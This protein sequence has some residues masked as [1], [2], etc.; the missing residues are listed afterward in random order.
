MR[1]ATFLESSRTLAPPNSVLAPSVN[2]DDIVDFAHRLNFYPDEKQAQILRSTATRGILNCSRQWGK[3]T[4][5]AALA[6]HRAYARPGSEIIVASPSAR[7]SGEFMR[8][9]IS[10]LSALHLRFT[11][12]PLHKI[13]AILPNGSRLIGL[14]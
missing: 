8:R 11:K 10:M 2:S 7:Q 6:V 12:D 3:T 13:S 5:I 14:P 1:R 9:A 4:V